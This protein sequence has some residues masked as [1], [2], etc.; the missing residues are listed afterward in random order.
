MTNFS[1]INM[2]NQKLKSSNFNVKV[3]SFEN[4]KMS[5][6]LMKKVKIFDFPKKCRNDQSVP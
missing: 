5:K 1:L 4:L 2:R 6:N 3:K